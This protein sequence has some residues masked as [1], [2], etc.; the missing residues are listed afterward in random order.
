[1]LQR[2]SEKQLT[3][4]VEIC[5]F[6]MNNLVLMGLL[7]SKHRVR[8][9]EEK[10]RAVAEAGQPQTPSEVPSFLDSLDLVKGVYLILLLLIPSENLQKREICPEM[11]AVA[12]IANP[13]KFRQTSRFRRMSVR[14]GS[15]ESGEFGKNGDFGENGESGEIS[16]DFKI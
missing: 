4:N 8:P 13:A 2:L 15:D 14:Q 1:M 6:R 10:V 3:L 16:P 7:L 5:T 11:H 12:K 9:T